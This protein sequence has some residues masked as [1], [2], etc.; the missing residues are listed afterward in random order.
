ML[1]LVFFR[2]FFYTNFLFSILSFHIGCFFYIIVSRSHHWTADLRSQHRFF[3]F[4][5]KI[6]SLQF[7]PLDLGCFRFEIRIFFLT[8]FILSYLIRMIRVMEFGWFVRFAGFFVPFC[9]LT[10]FLFN[11]STLDL[12]RIEL[13]YF[14]SAFY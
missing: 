4:F 1:T 5:K 14:L 6:N 7:C 8:C 2:V 3:F 13:Y 10:F 11:H 9:L 12:L